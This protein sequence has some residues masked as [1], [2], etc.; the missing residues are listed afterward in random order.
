MSAVHIKGYT[1]AEYTA[2][3]LMVNFFDSEQ[4]L[5]VGGHKG[6]VLRYQLISQH[7]MGTA[8]E[9]LDRLDIYI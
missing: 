6:G 5:S 9:S 7:Q 2:L 3:N 8:E 1:L 4:A